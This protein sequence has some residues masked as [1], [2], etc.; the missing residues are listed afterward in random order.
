MLFTVKNE[1]GALA[2]ALDIIGKHD[3]NLR[4]LRSRPIKSAMWQYYFYIE[5]EGNVNTR[6]GGRMIEDL[7]EYCAKVK[8]VG[9]YIKN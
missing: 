1:A 2:K 4:T 3:F 9:T 6:E 5:A 8:L 7:S